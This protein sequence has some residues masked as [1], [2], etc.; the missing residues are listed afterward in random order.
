MKSIKKHQ[1][2]FYFFLIIFM[3]LTLYPMFMLF[4]GSLKHQ[5]QLLGNPWFFSLPLHFRNYRI[6]FS[7]ISWSIVNSF[8]VTG[9][10]IL[11]VLAA[12]ALA[13][14]VL[15][16]RKFKG[17]TFFYYYIVLLLMVPGFVILVPQFLVIHKMGLHN[18]YWGQILPPAA[19][20]IALGTMLMTS[21]FKRI[22]N[23]L[24]E[25]ARIEGCRDIPLLTN[26]VFP[27]CMPIFA[28]VTITTGLA[29]WNNYMWSLIVTSGDKV[30]PVIVKISRLRASVT[31]GNG[32]VFA[33]YM[34]A[35]LPVLILFFFA[36]K[37]FV[38]GLT[39]G[40]VKG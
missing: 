28:T 20:N 10:G 37:S 30:V 17:R 40:A 18:T 5:I 1:L 32:P 2:L 7:Q 33:A 3:F 34:I 22:P 14:Y 11:I 35:A 25:S 13:S 15:A 4:C 19:N 12:S 8:I 26:I 36:S 31:E 39:A 27:L 16:L 24:I 38:E 29:I 6:A 9:T 21:A 23:S